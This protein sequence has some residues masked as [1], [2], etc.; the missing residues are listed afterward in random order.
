MQKSW[1]AFALALC[2]I[3]AAQ[4]QNAPL[5][6]TI[7]SVVIRENRIQTM[8]GNQNRNIQIIDSKQIKALPVKSTTELLSYIAGVDLQQRGPW[9]AQADVNIQGSTF[10]EVLVLV[11][12]VKM[13]DPQTGHNMLNLPIPLSSI[14]HIEVLFGPASRVYGINALAGAINIITKIPAQNEVDAQV[15]SGSSFKQDT[16][17][18]E[19]YYGWGT[20]ASAALAGKNQSHVISVAHDQGNGYR[21]NTAFNDTRLFYQDRFELNNKNSL[22]AIAGYA[23]NTYGANGFYSAPGDIN[24]KE[25]AQT[26]LGSIAYTYHPNKNF[27]ITPRISYKYGKDDYIYRQSDPSF[28]RNIHETNVVTGEVES[29][30]HLS[31]GILGA[32]VELR[33]EEINSTN[34]GKHQRNNLGIYAEYKH[35]FSDKFNASAGIYGNYNSDFDFEVFPSA[36]LG[37][38]FLPNWKIFANASTG[39]RLPTYTDLYYEDPGN[40]GNPNLKPEHTSY[41]EGGLQ[42][43]QPMFFAQ[44]TY[45][46][47]HTT[48]FID[49][50]RNSL[51]D[52]WLPVNDPAITTP[53]ISARITYKLSQNMHLPSGYDITLNGSYMYLDQTIKPTEGKISKYTVEALRHQMVLSLRSL[54]F[55]HIQ[56]DFNARYQQRISANDYTLLDARIG[57]VIKQWNLYA[58]VNNILDTQY[59]EIGT[60]P[61]PGRWF[62][63][64]LKFNAMWK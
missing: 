32:G 13:S 31:H 45:F 21:Y 64:G 47:K 36:D 40:L 19:T 48:D 2:S 44:L 63:L 34:L 39:E 5:T 60:V 41:A 38:R 50:E 4:A 54:L 30:L 24:S 57:Y 9:G 49:W 6:S 7:D 16:S 59:R 62:T 29:S 10:D 3:T 52:R 14:D 46:Y 17:T 53:G 61:L 28:Y 22:E 25:T 27:S 15:Y 11:D 35:F 8:Y 43:D 26:A 58:D 1:Q 20:Q 12:G 33:N 18:G 37:Y 23:Y 56:F 51:N 42:F 55:H